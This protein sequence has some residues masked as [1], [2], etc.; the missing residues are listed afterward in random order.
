MSTN[1]TTDT[2][3]LAVVEELTA[4]TIYAGINRGQLE[5]LKR[6]YAKGTTDDEFALFMNTAQRL[7]LDPFARQ[8]YAVKRWDS[9]TKTEVMATQVAIDGYRAVAEDTGECDGREGPF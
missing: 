3:A 2:K 9:T 5:L 8:I 6:T 4:P 1:P 7:K